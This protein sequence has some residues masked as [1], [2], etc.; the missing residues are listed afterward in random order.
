MTKRMIPYTTRPNKRRK[1]KV[2]TDTGYIQPQALA[3]YLKAGGKLSS[4][5][6]PKKPTDP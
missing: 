4:I 6:K 5:L 3:L 2:S 1:R